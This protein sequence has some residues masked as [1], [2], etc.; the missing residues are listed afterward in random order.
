MAANIWHTCIVYRCLETVWFLQVSVL[1][2]TL[3]ACQLHS[4]AHRTRHGDDILM[5]GIRRWKVPLSHFLL[6]ALFLSHINSKHAHTQELLYVPRLWWDQV[7]VW[8]HRQRYKG[9]FSYVSF[10]FTVR[11]RGVALLRVCM[12][13]SVCARILVCTQAKRWGNRGRPDLTMQSFTE[14]FQ[15]AT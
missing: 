5:R 12:C 8:L 1:T 10:F 4:R 13:A 3:S 11:Q 6:L 9:Q 7:R 14:T 15:W 2:P